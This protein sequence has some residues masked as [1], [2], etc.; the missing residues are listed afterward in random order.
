MLEPSS[1]EYEQV[2]LFVVS[3]GMRMIVIEEGNMMVDSISECLVDVIP[4]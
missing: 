1:G 2:I 3:R 4:E